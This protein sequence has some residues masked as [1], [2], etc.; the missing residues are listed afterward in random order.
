MFGIRS[1]HHL[2]DINTCATCGIW[3]AVQWALPQASAMTF[4]GSGLQLVCHTVQG[5]VQLGC[6]VR[7]KCTL[8]TE[9]F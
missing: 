4:D 9:G 5:L 1:L 8:A 6:A 7:V 2:E 3:F